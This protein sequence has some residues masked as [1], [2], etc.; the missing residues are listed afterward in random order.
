MRLERQVAF[1]GGAVDDMRV[2]VELQA[3]I[4]ARSAGRVVDLDLEAVLPQR[5]YRTEKRRGSGDES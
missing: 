3:D 1:A 5:R 2:G 4:T